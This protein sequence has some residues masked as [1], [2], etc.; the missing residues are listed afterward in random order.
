MKYHKITYGLLASLLFVSACHYFT[1]DNQ[2]SLLPEM[3]AVYHDAQKLFYLVWSPK[4]FN[5]P[6]N[7]KK[8]LA[9]LDHMK[10]DFHKVNQKGETVSTDPSFTA[11]VETVQSLLDDARNR[12]SQGSKD[13][14]L[15]QLRGVY[16]NCVSCH[17]RSEVKYDFVGDIPKVQEH[18]LSSRLARAE[19]LVASRQFETADKELLALASN[20]AGIPA[21]SRHML[22]TLKLW[23][24]IQV[25]V[26]AREQKAAIVLRNFAE[27]HILDDHTK[28]TINDW[29]VELQKIASR[30]APKQP[31]LPEAEDLLSYVKDNP[32]IDNDV[33]H[34]V[35][36]LKASSILH[37]LLRGKISNEQRKSATL[38]LGIAYLHTPITTL[39]IYRD[40]FLERCIRGYPHTPEAKQA[41]LLLKKEI[42]TRN[43][44]SLG[45]ILSREDKRRL[46]KLK[47][48][49]FLSDNGLTTS[50]KNIK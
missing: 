36:T 44:G 42:E 12:F 25:R 7:E 6:E 41:F 8:I 45:T 2:T 23:L 10:S 3:H 39:E 22:E 13:Y 16:A 38:L 15:W 18:S 27:S 50:H 35:A 49:T 43:T 31:L 46:K 14:A 5:D 40:L 28:D 34:L 24:V 19:F 1:E 47:E 32:S 30:K 20:L 4:E 11:S 37:K 29:R 26:K 21:S 9:L 33:K 48:L 17:S